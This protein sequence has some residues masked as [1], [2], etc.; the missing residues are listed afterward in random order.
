MEITSYLFNEMNAIEY[1]NYIRVQVFPKISLLSLVL[2]IIVV[3][4][5]I[6]FTIYDR[7][8]VNRVTL[9]LQTVIACYDIWSHS[10]PLWAR[11]NS[12]EGNPLCLAIAYQ[13]FAFPLFYSFLNVAIGINLQLVFIH[14]IF[15]TKKIE[16]GYY[17]GSILLTLLITIPPLAL[18]LLG[19]SEFNQCYLT[20]NDEHFSKMFDFYAVNLV[21]I[22]CMVYLFGI[23]ISTAV[24]L[25]SQTQIVQNFR[26][27][28]GARAS[29][30]AAR[31]V[32]IM[33]FRILLYPIVMIVS[34][35]GSLVAQTAYDLA[36][37]KAP[38][39]KVF[40]YITRSV[41]GTLNFAAF[42]CD[43]TVHSAFRKLYLRCTTKLEY[44]NSL[45]DKDGNRLT[46][47]DII[48]IE[49]SGTDSTMSEEEYDR[50]LEKF[51][52]TL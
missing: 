31:S 6:A 52:Q 3:L 18:G 40:S 23:V 39:L 2:A 32:K 37:N 15:I 17:I 7:K 4:T 45:G 48:K 28:R 42:F 51:I 34:N 11:E 30:D 44:H 5:M 1:K 50:Q 29:I 27:F 13:V 10:F 36:D 41:L 33:G 19:Y 24:K 16:A 43:P 25:N 47:S 22:I 9:R 14:G 20:S 8:L 12:K 21:T 26:L 49:S 35:I 46:Y 38:E